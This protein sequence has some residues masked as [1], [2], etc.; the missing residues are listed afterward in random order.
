MTPLHWPITLPQT[1]VAPY[2]VKSENALQAFQPDIGAAITRPKGS[3]SLLRGNAAFVLKDTEIATFETFF[4]TTLSRGSSRFVWRDPVTGIP[5]WWK[6]PAGETYELRYRL[7]NWAD[8][9]FPLLRLPNVLWFADYIRPDSS[10]SPAWV[11]DYENDVYG[12]GEDKV[13]AS[14]LPTIAGTY[15]VE[16]TTTTEITFGQET[17]VAGDI[18]EAQPTGTLRIVGYD[19]P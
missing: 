16:R 6:K 11:A 1:P 12:I 8:I 7:Q 14:K 19:L 18:T 2:S 9:S 13:P 10:W 4:E 3:A 17:L 5:Y 15:M